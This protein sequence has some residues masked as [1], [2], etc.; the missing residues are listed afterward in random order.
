M[1]HGA[2][3][4]GGRYGGG[5]GTHRPRLHP[6]P[7]FGGRAAARAV[8]RGHA[9]AAGRPGLPERATREPGGPPLR[10]PCEPLPAT[11]VV[12]CCVVHAARGFPSGQ[13]CHAR[14]DAG[15]STSHHVTRRISVGRRARRAPPARHRWRTAESAPRS[16]GTKSTVSNAPGLTNP[17]TIPLPGARDPENRPSG[18]SVMEDGDQ[19]RRTLPAQVFSLNTSATG[20]TAHA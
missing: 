13:A 9:G 2:G 15:H 5:P 10:R 14:A 3:A 7:G 12:T 18:T 8:D 1:G 20:P 19:S 4:G 17:A 16:P 11:G 6:A